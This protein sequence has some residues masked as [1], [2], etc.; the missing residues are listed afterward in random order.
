MSL[1]EDTSP[2]PASGENPLPTWQKVNHA[3]RIGT[4]PMFTRLGACVWKLTAVRSDRTRGLRPLHTAIT[5]ES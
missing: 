2:P 1:G 3:R 4:I 5:G